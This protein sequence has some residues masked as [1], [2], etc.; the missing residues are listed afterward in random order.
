MRTPD[1]GTGV[2]YNS[3]LAVDADHQMIIACDVTSD[4]HD[5]QQFVPLYE[6]AVKNAGQVPNETSADAGYHSGA[7]YLYIEE[8]RIDAYLPD[9]K[10]HAET[11]EQGNELIPPFDRRHFRY[12]EHERGYRCPANAVLHFK[13]RSRRN[14]VKFEV[15]QATACLE[16][17][18]RK[19]CI[20]KPQARF[21]QIQ[22]Y[23]NDGFK[24]QMRAKLHSEEGKQRYL[25]RLATVEPVFAQLKQHLGFTK[26]LVRGIEKV[27]AE[28]RLLCTA[29]NIK[30]LAFLTM[31]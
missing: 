24:A 25:K 28:F 31:M 12:D 21:R 11:D 15:Y 26:Y 29:Y 6:Q 9:S 7:V 20:S 22:I 8:K 19:Q 16:C 2:C 1:G 27:K 4:E 30:K 23:E 17:D 14:G 3:Q 5:H 18:L 13:R 10:F